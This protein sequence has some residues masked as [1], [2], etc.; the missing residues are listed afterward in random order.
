MYIAVNYIGGK[1]IPGEIIPDD[2]PRDMLDW[3]IQAGAVRKAAPDP[4]SQQQNDSAARQE[5]EVP[6]PIDTPEDAEE[7]EDIQEPEDEIDEDEEI[8]EI[9]VMAGIVQDSGNDAEQPAP[10]RKPRT[11]SGSKKAPKGGKTK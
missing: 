4:D 3:L 1:Y 7:P 8:P 9:D 11:T 2:M 6:D 10:A 5:A